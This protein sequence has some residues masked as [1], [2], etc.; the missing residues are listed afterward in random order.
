VIS[1]APTTTADALPD[2]EALRALLR[3]TAHRLTDSNSDP[4]DLELLLQRFNINLEWHPRLGGNAPGLLRKDSQGFAVLVARP[5]L[6]SGTISPTPRERFTIAHEFAHYLLKRCG[7]S[8]PK[9]RRDYWRIEDVCN[10]FAARLLVPDEA[11]RAALSP[12]S[13]LNAIRVLVAARDLAIRHQTSLEVVA[14]RFADSITDIAVVAIST[15]SSRPTVIW[16]CGA[17]AL[18]SVGRGSIL[19]VNSPLHELALSAHKWHAGAMAPIALEG[20]HTAACARLT[21]SLLTAA[22]L[23]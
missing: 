5:G 8:D 11:V 1:P 19:R 21:R 15:E 2:V 17:K 16:S 18:F 12:R 3:S 20:A 13:A 4:L 14:R 9:S 6:A 10:E 23:D 22:I 7:I